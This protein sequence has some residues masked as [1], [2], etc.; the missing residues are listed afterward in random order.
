M[1]LSHDDS[2]TNIVLVLLLLLLLL[3]LSSPV[4]G[5]CPRLCSHRSL[6]ISRDVCL[7]FDVARLPSSLDRLRLRSCPSASENVRCVP[8]CPAGYT[9]TGH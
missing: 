9:Q 3:L 2:T 1:T 4:S 7:Y 6:L 8:P 5:L